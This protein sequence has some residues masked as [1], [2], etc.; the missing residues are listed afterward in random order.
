MFNT[1]VNPIA[2]GIASFF[3]GLAQLVEHLICIQKVRSSTLL[4]SIAVIAQL[5][6]A[7]H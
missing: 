4:A 5:V 6:R 3:G 7:R 2:S 1:Q